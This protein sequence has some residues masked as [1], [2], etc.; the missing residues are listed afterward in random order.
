LFNDTFELYFAKTKEDFKI[1]GKPTFVSGISHKNI[2]WSSDVKYKFKNTD[3]MDKQWWDMT[4]EHFI[5]WMRTAG[6]PNFRKLWGSVPNT[7]T[8]GDKSGI[9]L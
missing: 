7:N 6:L 1:N 8:V 3:K 9:S 2:A 5:V 4:D